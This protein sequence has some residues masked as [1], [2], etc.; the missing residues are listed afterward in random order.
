MLSAELLIVIELWLSVLAARS[1]WP[2]HLGLGFAAAAV[3]SCSAAGAPS[4]NF[5]LLRSLSGRS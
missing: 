4:K 1:R 3:A 2:G 5:C